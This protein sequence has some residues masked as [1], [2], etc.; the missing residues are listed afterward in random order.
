MSDWTSIDGREFQRIVLDE[1]NLDLLA[2]RVIFDRLPHAFE[3]KEQYLAW[4][5][6]LAD[7]LEVDARDILVVGSAATGRS[8]NPRKQFKPY[9]MGSDIDIAVISSRH[10]DIAWAW[11]RRTNPVIIGLDTDRKRLFERH[12][13][14]YIYHGMIA[15]NYFLSYLP[16]GSQ[17]MRE[18]QRSEG[19]LPLGLRGQQQTVRI[20]KDSESLRHSQISG[21][22][23][24]KRYL[25]AKKGDQG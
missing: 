13:E 18:L 25:E 16:F 23:S 8:L 20:Y 9:R 17:W 7:G 19:F 3:S 6:A 1:S 2:G 5:H 12:R 21:L 14:D 11:F 22:S 15:A 24:Y 10:F 4:R